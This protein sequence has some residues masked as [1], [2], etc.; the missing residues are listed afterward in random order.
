MEETTIKAVMTPSG[1]LTYPGLDRHPDVSG[2]ARRYRAASKLPLGT[3][4]R[5][6]QMVEFDA[7]PITT[8]ISGES[9]CAPIYSSARVV[10]TR[11]AIIH[12]YT[13][14]SVL[15]GRVWM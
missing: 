12:S 4:I 14:I 11:Q 6:M 7:F 2:P 8:E 5:A 10:L 13:H 3:L 1:N 9:A 15:R